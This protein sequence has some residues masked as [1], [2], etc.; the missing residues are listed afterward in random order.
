MATAAFE[1]LANPVRRQLLELLVDGPK[2]AGSLAGQIDLS[3]PAVSE[4]LQVL[5]RTQL[6][7][8]RAVGRQRYYELNPAPL[9][10]VRGWLQQFERY[11]EERFDALADVLDQEE[12]E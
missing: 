3:R 8:D 6:V 9:L 2:T 1:A 11:W 10:E 4:H 12:S 5:R 7:R